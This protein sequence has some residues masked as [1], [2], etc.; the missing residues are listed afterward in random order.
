MAFLFL[1]MISMVTTSCLCVCVVLSVVTA[2]PEY[3]YH[4]T[5]FQQRKAY[6]DSL[7]MKTVMTDLTLP[8]SNFHWNPE[9]SLEE[10]E[11]PL[12]DSPDNMDIIK[13]LKHISNTNLQSSLRLGEETSRYAKNVLNDFYKVRETCLV[14]MA[15]SDHFPDTLALAGNHIS[16]PY[17]L[18]KASGIQDDLKSSIQGD[19]MFKRGGRLALNPSG[20]RK[21]RDINTDGDDDDD[22]EFLNNMKQ[23]FEKRRRRLQFNPSGW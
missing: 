20:W 15:D 4:L 17:N 1:D 8:Q 6:C 5:T 23:L 19:R 16:D 22:E 13:Q 21:R 12:Y 14:K 9:D 3:R 10:S 2:F 7:A 18:M 11:T